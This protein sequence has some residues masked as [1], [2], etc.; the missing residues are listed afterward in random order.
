[1]RLVLSLAILITAASC[2]TGS[3]LAQKNTSKPIVANITAP[4]I[5]YKTMKDYSD[6]LPVTLSD[7]GYDIISYPDP[8]DLIKD[9]NYQ[10]PTKLKKGYLL[11][12][13]GISKHSAF[14][15]LSYEAYSQLKEA[16]S[17]AELKDL[18][19]DRDPFVAIYNCGK[20]SQYKDLIPE[21]NKIIVEKKFLEYFK[22]ILSD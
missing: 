21:L 12:N 9:Q 4:V 10:K 20:R 15:S 6:L 3:S 16:P 5:I 19:V 17:I 14:I 2:K 8:R 13:R 18:V 1:M 7:N 11:D 22:D